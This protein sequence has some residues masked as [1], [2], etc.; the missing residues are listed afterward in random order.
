MRQHWFRIYRRLLS[1]TIWHFRLVLWGGA[2]L[3]GVVATFFAITSEMGN[4]LF[5][6][7]IDKQPWLA[8]VIPPLGLMLIA[9]LTR[10][11]FAGTEG[12]GI[13]QALAVLDG[14]KA[15]RNRFLSPRIIVGKIVLTV[16]GLCSGASIGREGPTVQIGAALMYSLGHRLRRPPHYLRRALI[17]SGGAAGIAAA[18]NTPLAGIVFAIEEISRSFEERASGIVLTSV[19]FAGLTAMALMGNY[20]YFGQTTAAMNQWQDWLAI[21]LCGVVG[22]LL[23]GLFSQSLISGSRL[24]AGFR[25]THPVILAGI[26]GLIVALI[27]VSSGGLTYGTG[28]AEA[29]AI[30]S[31][32]E[33]LGWAF[34]FWKMLASISSYLSGI[35]GGIFAPSLSTGAGIG[36]DMAYL[37]P[38]LTPGV[39]IILGMVGYFTGVVQTPITAFVIVMEMT[40]NHTMLLPLMATAFIAQG[41]SRLV[42]HQPIYRVLAEALIPSHNKGHNS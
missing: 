41:A 2:L 35:P 29:K 14:T 28:Y 27:G 13:P 30:I 40:N 42:C 36:A 8:Y 25:S 19:I 24:L 5:N 12:S 18:F 16:L 32:Q 3:V 6:H 9:W 15:Q 37:M 33:G 39:L 10:N 7:V 11:V 22:G 20:S 31:N 34:P 38:G 4:E 17:I 1:R 26:C 21:P 23:G